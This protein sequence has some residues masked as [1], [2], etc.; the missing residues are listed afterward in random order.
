M[1]KIL[2]SIDGLQG[3]TAAEATV[4]GLAG[5][6]I[7]Q[8]WTV[9]VCARVISR[10]YQQRLSALSDHGKVRCFTDAPEQGVTPFSDSGE[11]TYDLVWVCNGYLACGILHSLQQ[12]CLRGQFLFQHISWP[13]KPQYHQCATEKA[14]SWR[15]LTDSAFHYASL[16][17]G[18]ITPPALTLLP[19]AYNDTDPVSDDEPQEPA[20][21]LQR[22]LWAGE[23]TAAQKDTLGRDFTRRGIRVD[24]ICGQ[25]SAGEL[26][27]QQ[28]TRYQ[29]VAGEHQLIARALCLGI[30]ACITGKAGWQ[31]YPAHDDL[32]AAA[33]NFF[34][35]ADCPPMECGQWA[36]ALISGYQAALQ[37]A[38]DFREEACESW[39]YSALLPPLLARLPAPELRVPDTVAAEEWRLAQGVL[40]SLAVKRQPLER[41]LKHRCLSETRRAV[42]SAMVAAHPGTGRIGVMITGPQS[43]SGATE[44]TLLSVQQQSLP[45]ESVVLL[46]DEV[47]AGF[48]HLTDRLLP[49]SAGRRE[50]LEVIGQSTANSWLMLQPGTR[51]LPDTLL[52]FAVYLLEHP[53]TS[54]CYSDTLEGEEMADARL[55]LKPDCNIDLLRACHYPGEE[56]L[57]T[58]TCLSR[59]LPESAGPSPLP[60]AELMWRAI[61][62]Y[63]PGTLGHLTEAL[64]LIPDRSPPADNGEARRDEVRRHLARCGIDGVVTAGPDNAPDRVRY[65]QSARPQVSIIIP[66]KDHQSL[67]KRCLDSVT[68]LTPEGG[69]EILIVDNGSSQPGAC[70]YLGQLQALKLSNLRIL[71]WSAPFNFAALCNFAAAQAQGEYLLFLNNDC[72]VTE[73]GW[74]TA[75]T[76]LAQRPEVGITG[77]RMCYP[78]GRLQHAGFIAG[79]EDSVTAIYEGESTTAEG[80]FHCLQATHEVS[81]VSAACMIVRRTLFETLGGFDAENFDY[82]LADVDL[83]FRMR[84]AG[85][86]VLWTPEATVSHMGGATRLSAALSTPDPQAAERCRAALRTRWKTGLCQDIRYQRHLSR[87]GSLFSLSRVTDRLQSPLPGRPLP[88]IVAGHINETGCGH[89]R[90]IQP[91]RL[92]EQQLRAEGGLIHGLP[93]A[94]D[95][96]GVSPDIVLLQMPF[97]PQIE[98][99][100]THLKQYCS[101]KIIMEYDD[102][103]I[104]LPL[105]NHHRGKLPKNIVSQLRRTVSLADRLVVSTPALAEAYAG[106]HPD[107]R[108]ALNRLDPELWGGLP[109]TRRRGKKPRVGWAGGN[110]HTGD[111]QILQPLICELAD[112]VDWV[113][114]GMKPQSAR[115]EFHPGVPFE[116]YPQK[117]ASLQLDLALVPLEINL[118]NECKSNLR[119]LELGACGI[120][121]ICSDIE[122][123]RGALP[124]TRVKNHFRHWL[125]AIREH[126]ADKE[127]LDRQ[128]IL[129]QQ[130]VRRH[131]LMTPSAVDEWQYA[132]LEHQEQKS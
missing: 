120:P 106:F 14:L 124:V 56:L 22:V 118:F 58:G 54:L 110:S 117:L 39:S 103:F 129:L 89:Y 123:Y 51:C 53:H 67:L 114:M 131:W 101:P 34:V 21:D 132:W 8:G 68:G 119:L 66:T 15:T 130:A 2:F 38:A 91:Y 127:A 94:I 41:W 28:L 29:V 112:E 85:Y 90:V 24:F 55:S 108:V 65:L 37:R 113:F 128:G 102:Y 44:R 105:K 76:E 23:L 111:L 30:P 126:L 26:T 104:N 116:W 72:E 75:L 84:Q 52:L 17:L 59:F 50:L 71:H 63:G 73:S 98:Q 97:D 62:T 93:A 13:L 4:F 1:Q 10:Q 88:V 107:I 115:C 45:P 36:E 83:C 27:N 77:A 49:A 9:D 20:G 42:L 60:M 87:S 19:L 70:E 6:F 32:L 80:Y 122:P 95:A 61:E 109:A 81:A 82:D 99:R 7:R 3:A 5:W 96:A 12:R 78:D 125:R 31:G 47:S 35:A 46:T 57:V 48:S 11:I 92:L 74:L 43:Q 79:P 18:G 16:A 100:I 25:E 121:V 69:I 64:L 40:A 86:L 33:D